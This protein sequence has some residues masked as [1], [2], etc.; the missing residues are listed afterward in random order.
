MWFWD[1]ARTS[2]SNATC[3][4]QEIEAYSKQRCHKSKPISLHYNL[5]SSVW[6]FSMP[7]S[8]VLTWRELRRSGTK[9]A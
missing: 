4:N 7:Q 1:P 6:T 8:L 9:L 3:N 2:T 5:V